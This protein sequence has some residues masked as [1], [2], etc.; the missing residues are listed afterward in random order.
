L[1]DNNAKPF[2]DSV[3]PF[4]SATLIFHG[5][6]CDDIQCLLEIATRALVAAK[7]LPLLSWA[8]VFQVNFVIRGSFLNLDRH[9][10]RL[11][12]M[13]IWSTR[14]SEVVVSQLKLAFGTFQSSASSKRKIV[15]SL[16]ITLCLDKQSLGVLHICLKII[17]TS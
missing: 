6:R 15:P 5:I 14:L 4:P 8:N 13:E 17:D 12:V 9:L 3:P 16:S 7:D 1:S 10:I 2:V 11:E